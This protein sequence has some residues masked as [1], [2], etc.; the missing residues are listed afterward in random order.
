LRL[1]DATLAVAEEI[2]GGL[3]VA[4]HERVVARDVHQGRDE[5]GKMRFLKRLPDGRVLRADGQSLEHWALFSVLRL[6][7]SARP[8]AESR[9]LTDCQARKCEGFEVRFLTEGQAQHRNGGHEGD[10]AGKSVDARRA[11]QPAKFRIVR[12]VIGATVEKHQRFQSLSF[13]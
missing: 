1:G 5:R 7:L 4:M 12:V 6:G 8:F 2:V 10:Q 3:D 13:S 11:K 9:L